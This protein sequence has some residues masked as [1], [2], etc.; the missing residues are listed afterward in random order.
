M[1]GPTP[2]PR[3]LTPSDAEGYMRIRREMLED[4]PWAFSASPIAPPSPQADRGLDPAHLRVTLAHA[5]FA[6]FGLDTPA[7]A[8]FHAPRLPSSPLIGV[9]LLMRESRLKRRHIAWILSVYVTP[10]QRGKGHARALLTTCIAHARA[11]PAFAGVSQ[12]QL[13]VSAASLPAQ[14]VYE[15]MGFVPW[16]REPAAMNIDGATQD[17]IHMSLPLT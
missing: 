4:S 6:Y 11:A 3:L 14:R 16:G 5:D 2:L 8:G 7:A 15:S 13:G 12:L 1:P 9:A 10:A 17:E